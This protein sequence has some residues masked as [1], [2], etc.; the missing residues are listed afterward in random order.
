MKTAKICIALFATLFAV[1][2]SALEILPGD[3]NGDQK[4]DY[5]VVNPEKLSSYH[6]FILWD[7]ESWATPIC[8]GFIP[9]GVTVEDYN[10]RPVSTRDIN[11]DGIADILFFESFNA[12]GSS[13]LKLVPGGFKPKY[14]FLNNTKNLGLFEYG[15]SVV[16]IWQSA[17]D[18][19]TYINVQDSSH[20]TTI[21]VMRDFSVQIVKKVYRY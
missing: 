17:S 1:T 7:D 18:R 5:F 12:L 20:I 6:A 13:S 15:S 14:Q 21:K 2:V 10:I 8:C 11:F 3:F 9:P 19:S 16:K 4:Q